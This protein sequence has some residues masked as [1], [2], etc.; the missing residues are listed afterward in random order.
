MED[1]GANIK[2]RRVTGIAPYL[3]STEY[4]VQAYL[5]RTLC[6]PTQFNLRQHVNMNGIGIATL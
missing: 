5:F 6:P 3:G 2:F 4:G 1:L